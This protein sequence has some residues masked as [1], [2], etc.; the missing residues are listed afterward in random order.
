MRSPIDIE[1]S[2]VSMDFCGHPQC[3]FDRLVSW[4]TS[5]K[6]CKVWLFRRRVCSQSWIGHLGIGFEVRN[7]NRLPRRWRSHQNGIAAAAL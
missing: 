1:L 4:P 6:T 7:L 5:E 2:Q 3:R